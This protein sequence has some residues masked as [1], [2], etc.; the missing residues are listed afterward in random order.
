MGL[1]IDNKGIAITYQ[2]FPGN[3]NDCLTYRP[4]LFRIKMDYALKRVFVV[5]DTGMTS[6]DN[7]W[8]TLSAGDGYVLSMCVRDSDKELKNYVLNQESYK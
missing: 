4:N 5:A 3:T 1:F 7:I 6:G 2:R 8:Y